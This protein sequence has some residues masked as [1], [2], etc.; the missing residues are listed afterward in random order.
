MR[1]EQRGP[2]L[3]SR[4]EGRPFDIALG[5]EIRT[6]GGD[7]ITGDAALAFAGQAEIA[8]PG[9]GRAGQPA[10]PYGADAL[11]NELE[12][13]Y[14]ADRQQQQT[15]S[16]DQFMDLRRG[17]LSLADYLAEFEHLHSEA[18][19]L[20]R[21][22][23]NAIGRTHLLLRHSGIHQAM[24]EHVLLLE[25]NDLTRY[26]AIFRHL[27]KI[28]RQQLSPQRP[29][30][31]ADN[32]AYY[33]ADENYDEYYDWNE[34][35]EDEYF[36]E[37]EP[38]GDQAWYHDEG[39]D[40]WYDW[41]PDET[42][43]ME[44]YFGKGKSKH[45][46][47]SKGKSRN[48][49]K[50]N[51]FYE[52]Y[53]KGKRGRGGKPTSSSSSSAPSSSSNTQPNDHNK[54]KQGKGFGANKGCSSCGSPNHQTASCPW[55]GKGKGHKSKVQFMEEATEQTSTGAAFSC[56]RPMPTYNVS[57]S[58]F[59]CSLPDDGTGTYHNT[60]QSLPCYHTVRGV[61]RYGLLYDPGAASNLMGTQTLLDYVDNVLK[62][63]GHGMEKVE[64]INQ[65]SFTGIDGK[66]SQSGAKIRVPV[67]IGPI[68]SSFEADTIGGAGDRCP[69]LLSNRTAVERRLICLHGHFPNRDGLLLVPR[70]E[71]DT[72]CVGIRLLLT[73]S[74][75]YLLP[76]SPM[77][78]TT[79]EHV[80][81]DHVHQHLR[82]IREHMKPLDNHGCFFAVAVNKIPESIQH[83]WP[84][85][86]TD[87]TEATPV[88]ITQPPG[89]GTSTTLPP[90][91]TACSKIENLS[92][93]VVCP[94]CDAL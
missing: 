71:D 25:N 91:C 59:H 58:F 41:W 50:Y 88:P 23:L 63:T 4:L 87:K 65:R 37:E 73:D 56:D 94:R 42:S 43:E 29:P 52:N 38:D 60:T 47:K 12:R 44:A 1:A 39:G 84:S 16:I 66:V 72:Q 69:M 57:G 15:A 81:C 19:R 31:L 11:L 85:L 21:F 61:E 32:P 62:P 49:G 7:L 70:A 55:K 76:L 14:G 10:V 53:Y 54:G 80:E 13:V 36:Y 18:R 8:A 45:K 68:V 24:R 27:E 22:E 79:H 83:A 89:L 75:H 2:A 86:Q 82:K 74:G 3:A 77:N 6:Q 17:K 48:K 34:W 33:G 20:A 30:T 51:S 40:D 5:L 92:S 28:A 78:T 46:G 90:T 64:E 67:R 26:E 9:P 93:L 35:C